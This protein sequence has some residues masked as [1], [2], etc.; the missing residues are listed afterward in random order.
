MTD[1][2]DDQSPACDW[3]VWL[4]GLGR[5]VRRAREFLGLS[6]D[7]IARMAGVSQGAVSRL[8]AGRGLATPLL[9]VMK[10]VGA[11]RQ[12][13][14]TIDPDLL[15]PAVRR[16]L[17]AEPPYAPGFRPVDVGQHPIAAE[18][19]LEEI[20]R[21]YRTVP[22]RHRQHLASVVRATVAALA[23]GAGPDD[24]PSSSPSGGGSGPPSR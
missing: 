15:S 24:A 3:P 8:E 20:I 11:M 7:Q 12:A 14:S 5:H 13:M 17:A 4:R 23:S 16:L 2:I 22:E 18:P 6:Q 19:A 9:V 1:P 21:L 10:I